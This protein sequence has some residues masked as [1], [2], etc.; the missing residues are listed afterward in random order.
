MLAH[1]RKLLD[2]GF[3][4][5]LAP[6]YPPLESWKQDGFDPAHPERAK[7]DGGS[8]ELDPA[9]LALL[10]ADNEKRFAREITAIERG[11]FDDV[12]APRGH[13]ELH[14][15]FL[16][17]AKLPADARKAAARE[18]FAGFYPSLAESAELFRIECAHCHGHSGGGDGPTASFIE[19]RPRD[20]RRGI[21]K[22]TSVSDGARPTRDDLRRVITRGVYGTSMPAFARLSESE[23]EGLIDYVRLLSLRGE[24]ERDLV[25]AHEDGDELDDAAFTDAVETVDARWRR[26]D[27]KVVAWNGPIPEPTAEDLALGERLF[28]DPAKGNCS[29][30]HGAEGRGDGPVAFRV[31]ER[32]RKVAAYQDAW[33]F[34]ILPRNLRRDPL[35]GGRRPIDIYRRIHNGINGG[36]MPSLANVLDAQETWALVHYT[37]TLTVSGDDGEPQASAGAR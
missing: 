4:T 11:E 24:V 1:V 8:G 13:E 21:F 9:R 34:D 37:R 15:R 35:R 30:C 32:G 31:D 20:F 7:G 36:P 33:G 19:P 29:A 16:E 22:W 10:R 3:G 5:P 26:A 28:R 12:D 14:A 18:L 6:H 27:S 17:T 25:L 2:D 23:R